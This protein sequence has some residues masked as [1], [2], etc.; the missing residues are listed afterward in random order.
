MRFA[1]LDGLGILCTDSAE[2]LEYHP[3]LFI[4]TYLMDAYTIRMRF[5]AYL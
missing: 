1:R 5:S 4:Q 2:A 3:K